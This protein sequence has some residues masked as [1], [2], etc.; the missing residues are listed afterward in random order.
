MAPSEKRWACGWK[1]RD[2]QSCVFTCKMNVKRLEFYLLSD[3]FKTTLAFSRVLCCCVL[4]N[5]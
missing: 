1:E 5:F 4:L 2:E 3:V